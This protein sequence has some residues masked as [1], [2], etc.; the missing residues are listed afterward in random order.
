MQVKLLKEVNQP[1]IYSPT[2]GV[3]VLDLFAFVLG[4]REDEQEFVK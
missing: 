3:L 4:Q 1:V 2:N